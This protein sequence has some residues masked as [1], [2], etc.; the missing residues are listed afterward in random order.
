MFLHQSSRTRLKTCFDI[1]LYMYFIFMKVYLT[2]LYILEKRV[3]VRK[4]HDTI[5][6][7]LHRSKLQLFHSH[8]FLEGGGPNPDS[9]HSRLINLNS[10]V[11][12]S[13]G[14]GR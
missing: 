1:S 12:R 4:Y 2:L 6:V 10:L 14:A 11:R 9:I 3:F 7:Q 13:A 5:I 8:C